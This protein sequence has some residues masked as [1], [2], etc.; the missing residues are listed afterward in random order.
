MS[1]WAPASSWLAVL[2]SCQLWSCLGDVQIEKYPEDAA[3]ALG[4]MMGVKPLE[5][6]C[7]PGVV[8]CD[9]SWIELCALGDEP[10]QTRWERRQDCQTFALCHPDPGRCEVPACSVGELK[11]EGAVPRRCNAGRTGFAD[12]GE[13]CQDRAHCSPDSA[14]CG[15]EGSEAPC[16]LSVP[17]EPNELRCNGT[18]IQRCRADQSD[19]D[20][21]ALCVTPALCAASLADCQADPASCLCQ[22]PACE[23]GATRCELQTLLRCNADQTA[24]EFVEECGTPALCEAG[25]ALIPVACQP[26]LCEAGTFACTNTGDLQ[27]CNSDQTAY[28][29]QTTCPGGAAFCSAALGVCTETPC[30]P[31]D[32]AC[33]GAQLLICREDQSD[34]DLFPQLCATPELCIDDGAGVAVCVPPF[35]PTNDIV[36]SN[37]QLQRCNAGR[38]A[39]ADFGPPCP[40]ADLCS[41]VRDR[42][43]FCVPSRRE[44]TPDLSSSRT[45]SADGNS[46]GPLTFCPLGCIAAT[47]ACTTCNVGEYTCQGGLLSR[48]NDGFSFT[49][50]NRAADCSGS[51]RLTCAGNTVQSS[52]CGALGCNVARAACNECAGQQRRC[53]GTVSFRSCQLDGTFGPAS[54]CGAGLACAGAGQCVCTPGQA[55]CDGDTLLACTSGGNAIAAG[56]RCAG[57][58]GAVLR[59]CEDGELSTISCASAGLCAAATGADCP[60]CLNDERSCSALG[61]PLVCVGGQ[62]VAE[63]PCEPGFACEDAGACRCVAEELSC[64]GEQLFE[65][66]P[67]RTAL[68]PAAPRCAG[69]GLQVV[70]TEGQPSEIECG[71]GEVCTAGTG[72]VAAED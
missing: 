51:T 31:G 27:L 54:A 45:C 69:P 71:A 25:R 12:V 34:F 63:A 44:C 68:Q 55:S 49:P 3:P 67:T 10:G 62:R 72:C 8:R 43:D 33:S 40:R 4:S 21:V 36:C 46:F 35:C 50:L 23:A 6:A 18:E 37:S 16:C 52:P 57:P 24:F 17:C 64:V 38:T 42:C 9:D 41:D 2:L 28:V 56:E 39:Y 47:G 20:S 5:P 19:L 58:A 15:A 26:S 70:C 65:C 66:A 30:E 60:E 61:Q 32:R 7:V 11:C 29:T 53:D 59:S 1:S 14:K 48:C 22:E 13:E